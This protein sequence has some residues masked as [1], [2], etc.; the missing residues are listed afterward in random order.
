MKCLF[1]LCKSLTIF[2]LLLPITN[3][4]GQVLT[5]RENLNDGESIMYFDSEFSM[6]NSRYNAEYY[7]VYKLGIDNKLDGPVT[8][9]FKSGKV[10]NIIAG[11]SFI[12]VSNDNWGWEGLSIHYYETGEK[13]REFTYVNGV[14]E[15]LY[16]MY[17]ETGEKAKEY[18]YVNGVREGEY[19]SYY[20]NGAIFGV[21]TFKDNGYH[22]KNKDLYPNGNTKY[23]GTLQNGKYEG[24]QSWYH[25]NGE[26]KTRSTFK[27]GVRYGWDLKCSNGECEYLFSSDFSDVSIA[28]S[29]GWLFR[30]GN[31]EDISCYIIAAPDEDAE[32]YYINN[33]DERQRGSS[34][35]LSV[36]D[37]EDFQ[38]SANTEWWSGMEDEGFGLMC[39]FKDWDNYV[40]LMIT[41][42]GF[43]RVWIVYKGIQM[44][45]SEWKELDD[46]DTQSSVKLNIVR[47]G[48]NM[49][50]S[51]NQQ[52]V[53][54]TELSSIEGSKFG[55]AISGK[56]SVLFDNFKMVKT[57]N[58]ASSK[59]NSPNGNEW[60]GNGSGIIIS[61][62]GLVA[63]NFHVIDGASQIELDFKYRNEIQSFNAK[64]LRVDEA[65][66]LAILKIDDPKFSSLSSLNYNFKATTSLI[67]ESVF[68]LG[69]PKALT[70]MGKD[71][72]FTDGKISSKTGFRGDITSYQTTTPIQPGNSGGPLFDYR[73]NLIGINS[74]KIVSEDVDNV[75]YTIKAVYLKTLVESLNESIVLPSSNYPASLSLTA[76]IELL[77]KYVTLI[78]IR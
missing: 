32:E 56:Q 17:Y 47:L 29:Q 72:K 2:L 31:D 42:N 18:T 8:D 34:V 36:A 69:Y 33:K 71:I 26:L 46:V 55:F 61:K 73:G 39:G 76:K 38:M 77:S 75:A 14:M 78:K 40:R 6:V 7:R 5:A 4:F 62:N 25:E 60:L 12:D 22:G 51:I 37:N 54:K 59:P 52:S 70:S 16:I 44:G 49:F 10:Q 58:N 3:V 63:T 68:A 19:V 20:E 21:G 74:A 28:K 45:M 41:A 30:D 24:E 13:S 1:S 15:G 43:Y 50:F 11:A 65:N 66:D 48:G 27:N 9:Y 64:V 23:E 35:T 53:Y 57:A 67:G